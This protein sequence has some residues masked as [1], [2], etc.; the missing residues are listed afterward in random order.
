[1]S[2]AVY[3][4]NADCL[5]YKIKDG[6]L[7]SKQDVVKALHTEL[8]LNPELIPEDFIPIEGDENDTSLL[9]SVDSLVNVLHNV[10]YNEEEQSASVVTVEYESE[11]SSGNLELY[12]ATVKALSK[13]AG[14]SLIQDNFFCCDSREGNSFSTNYWCLG[15]Q[16]DVKKC[17]QDSVCLD[18]IVTILEVAEG[19][20]NVLEILQEV[21]ELTGRTINKTPAQTSEHE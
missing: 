5:L 6:S 14:I 12:N 20:E 7:R 8:I 17:W 13:I 11:L 10:Y 4:C 16:I 9:D 19:K 2:T 3:S 18:F 21:V 1:M 15:E